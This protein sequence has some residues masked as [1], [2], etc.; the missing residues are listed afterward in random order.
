MVVVAAVLMSAVVAIV[1]FEVG[2][3][4]IGISV[5]VVLVVLVVLV[6]WRPIPHV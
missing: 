2:P 3:V 4:V 1:D 6:Q 5:P